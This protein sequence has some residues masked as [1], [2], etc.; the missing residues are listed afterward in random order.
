M[1]K[2]CTPQARLCPFPF[3]G[4][5]SGKPYP[6]VSSCLQAAAPRSVHPPLPAASHLPAALCFPTLGYYSSSSHFLRYSISFILAY[7]GTGCKT[8]DDF[9]QR[10]NSN[11]AFYTPGKLPPGGKRPRRRRGR[12]SDNSNENALFDSF[13]RIHNVHFCNGMQR[14]CRRKQAGSNRNDRSFDNRRNWNSDKL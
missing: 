13:N 10:K 12:Q 9:F 2:P 8:P 6:A 4:G 3:Y 11:A 1:E 5:N 7:F 14:N